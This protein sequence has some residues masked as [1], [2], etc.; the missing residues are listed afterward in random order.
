MAEVRICDVT[1]RDGMQVLNRRN[2]VP[3]EIRLQLFDAL[4][5]ARIPYLEVGS[6]VNPRVIPA[7]ADTPELL[8]AIRPPAGTDL[9]VLV[10]TLSYYRKLAEQDRERK[11]TMVAL[12]LSASE[13]YSRANTRMDKDRAFAAAAEVAAAARADGYRLRGYLSCAFRDLSPRGAPVDPEVVRDDCERLLEMGCQSV[14]LSDTDGRATPQDVRRVAGAM[15]RRLG[16]ERVG[17]HLHD[18]YGQG[19]ANALVAHQEGVRIF[20]CS[21]GGIG[22]TRAVKHSVGNIAT[23]ELVAL[24]EG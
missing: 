13:A 3:V 15:T 21:V 1:M 9:A 6:F 5:R 24:L 10:P 20:D 14:S 8:A 2:V 17:V 11:V 12:F 4:R 19:I 23:E 16:P 18:R 22:G 7:M